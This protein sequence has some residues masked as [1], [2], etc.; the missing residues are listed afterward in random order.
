M[1]RVAPFPHQGVASLCAI[2]AESSPFL[3]HPVKERR[4]ADEEDG[5]VAGF[6][7]LGGARGRGGTR[8]QQKGRWVRRPRARGSDPRR[9][10]TYQQPDSTRALDLGA[11][12]R[13]TTSPRYYASR[14]SDR[15]PRSAAGLPNASCVRPIRTRASRHLGAFRE[16]T[17][18]ASHFFMCAPKM[19]RNTHALSSPAN[20]RLTPA[21]YSG[22]RSA[23][24]QE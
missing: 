19:S 22:I 15:E 2:G 24:T 18:L 11:H 7:G 13:K 9:P 12:C 17:T 5:L 21:P 14:G 1:Y 10:G 4:F 20:A 6:N 8:C 23:T 3:L 16:R